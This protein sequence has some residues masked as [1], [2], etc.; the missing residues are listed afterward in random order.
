MEIYKNPKADVKSQ[1]GG[2][3]CSR[4]IDWMS[5][6]LAIPQLLPA[7]KVRADGMTVLAN[8]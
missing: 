4:V 5:Q 2:R 3:V 8:N 1:A 7:T 6:L